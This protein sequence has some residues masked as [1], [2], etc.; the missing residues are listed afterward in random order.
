MTS[1]RAGT[2]SGD[3]STTIVSNNNRELTNIDTNPRPW[4]LGPYFILAAVLMVATM[5]FPLAG[6]AL[7]ANLL[8]AML[9]LLLFG[10]L[11][12]VVADRR[13]FR[14][15]GVLLIP[16]I[17]GNW[18]FDPADHTLWSRATAIITMLFM[19]TTTVAIFASIIFAKKVTADII[20]G[21]IA[22]YLLVAV[23]VANLLQLM[24]Y[25]EPGS[26]VTS[27]ASSGHEVFA[28]FLYFS[29][30]TITSVGYGDL[31]PVSQP[32]RV[33]ATATGVFGQLYLAILIAKLVGIY[34]AQS[35][36]EPER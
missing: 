20:F 3:R 29:L 5:A 23:I 33:V 32:A 22:V 34:T 1:A 30:V 28:E 17:A 36:T 15:L 13:M 19:A 4:Y 25:I 26:V 18:W 31:A 12:A 35:I 2:S 11:Y 8:K 21:A 24:N 9:S 14:V 16:L 10:A 7:G 27:V 6:G